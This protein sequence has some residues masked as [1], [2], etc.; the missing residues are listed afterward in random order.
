MAYQLPTPGGSSSLPA[1]HRRPCRFVPGRALRHRAAPVDRSHRAVGLADR[2]RLCHSR[3]HRTHHCRVRARRVRLP[4]AQAPARPGRTG[5]APRQ[6]DQPRSKPHTAASHG[7]R[8]NRGDRRGHTVGPRRRTLRGGELSELH[9]RSL[10]AGLG[11]ESADQQLHHR[12]AADGVRGGI[13]YLANRELARPVAVSA[14][15][16]RSSTTM[17]PRITRPSRPRT[18]ATA[19]PARPRKRCGRRI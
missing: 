9:H 4:R 6:R 12:A 16:R 1:W 18:R 8:R 13:R 17:L 5:D 10:V 2:Q 11:L 19:A 15:G 7:G 3:R 14:G